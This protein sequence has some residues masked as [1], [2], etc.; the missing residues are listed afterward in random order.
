MGYCTSWI[1]L[2]K[3]TILAFCSAII[4]VFS[5]FCNKK[6]IRIDLCSCLKEK[7]KRQ[8]LSDTVCFC[9]YLLVEMLRNARDTFIKSN[10]E[11]EKTSERK[12]CGGEREKENWEEKEH[13]KIDMLKK[14]RKNLNGKKFSK[15]MCARFTIYWKFN[16][17]KHVSIKNRKYIH[18]CK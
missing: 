4:F 1:S 12:R 10:R 6:F 5:L 9:V 8:K 7:E 3:K 14:K 11:K 15:C 13:R 17:H 18:I 2:K 16:V